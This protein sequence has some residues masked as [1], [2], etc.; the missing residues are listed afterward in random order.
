VDAKSILSVLTLGVN[1]DNTIA[2]ETEGE[3]AEEALTALEQLVES[4]FGE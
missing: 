4:N 3:Q 2:I 1:K